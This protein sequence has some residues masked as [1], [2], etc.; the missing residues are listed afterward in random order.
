MRGIRH[1]LDDRRIRQRGRR[2]DTR[3]M[4]IRESRVRL[5]G[6]GIIIGLCALACVVALSLHAERVAAASYTVNVTTDSGTGVGT[7]GDLRYAITHV[8]TS[9]DPANTI[10]I[11]AT[12]AITLASA[13]PAITKNV[14]I[15]GPGAAMLTVDGNHAVRV[16]A[17]N[18]GVTASISNLTIANGK[19]STGS[20]QEGGGLRNSGALTVANSTLS[21]NTVPSDGGGIYNDGTLTV[22]NS[23]LSGNSA[24]SFGGGIDNRGGLVNLLNSALSGNS[25]ASFGGGIYN[26]DGMVTVTNSILSSNTAAVGGGIYGDTN[27]T[28]NLINSTL[29]GNSA[30]DG[31]T[32]LNSG[33][34]TVA[35]ST[36]SGNHATST[37]NGDGGGVIDNGGTLTMTNSTLSSNSA[38]TDG[39]GILNFGTA[40]VTNCTIAGN[41]ATNR[42]GGIFNFTGTVTVANTIVAGNTAT[43]SAPDIGGGAIV[44]HGH[45]LIGNTSGGSGFVASDLTNVSPALGSLASNGGP[46]QTRALLPGSPAIG[47]GDATVCN[48]TTIPPGAPVGGKDQRGLPRPIATCAIGAFE[49]QVAPLG[50]NPLPP[51]QP[52]PS[53][54]GQPA[55]LP[56]PQSTIPVSGAPNPLPS[57]RP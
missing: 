14:A 4:R 21:G 32:I 53:P 27:G 46:T 6:R 7:T 38:T 50:P 15:A 1:V 11:T 42:G 12:G 33:I 41:S 8:N 23:T 45:N 52:G 30:G 44:S 25:A 51:S 24:A 22:T 13:L 56:R 36:F 37:S 3:G 40:T 9:T 26:R 19:G 34:V 31:G 10:T 17:V 35:A 43:G 49:P 20:G 55:P 29:S 57:R 28:V 39:G 48:S 16:F 5:I 18:S 2:S 54:S 47:A